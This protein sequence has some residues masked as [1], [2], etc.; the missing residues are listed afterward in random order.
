MSESLA[1]LIDAIEKA[2]SAAALTESVENLA[3]A[4]ELAAMLRAIYACPQPTIARLQGHCPNCGAEFTGGATNTCEFC[5]AI[6]NSGNYDWVLSEITQGSEFVGAN[7]AVDGLARARQTDPELTTELLEERAALIFWRW[8]D[9]QV[10]GKALG[11]L[12]D[13]LGDRWGNH[14]PPSRPRRLQSSRLTI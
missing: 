8:V 10:A 2:D 12:V 13:T 1:F 7:A 14:G 11:G 6:V 4:G 3:D 5:G 9:A